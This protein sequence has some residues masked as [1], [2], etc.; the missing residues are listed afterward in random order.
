[1]DKENAPAALGNTERGEAETAKSLYTE[2]P[3]ISTW[4]AGEVVEQYHF[5]NLYPLD[6]QGAAAA[7]QHLHGYGPSYDTVRTFPAYA[8]DSRATVWREWQY[9][10]GWKARD[11]ILPEMTVIVVALCALEAFRANRDEGFNVNEAKAETDYRKLRQRHLGITVDKAIKLA[12]AQTAVAAWNP[13]ANTIG[14]PAGECLYLTPTNPSTGVHHID[15]EPED[16]LTRALAATPGKTTRLWQDFLETL[17]G[18]DVL[19]ENALKVW[20]AAALFDGNPHHKAH[21]LYGDGNTGKSTY[22][23][24]IQAALGDYAGSARASVFTSEKDS[25]PAELLPFV[26]K[27]L[28]VL[29][30]LPL[31]AL[32]SDLLK[33]VTGGDSISVRGMRQNPRTETP[34]ATLMFSANELPSIRLVDN[35]L[36]RRLLVWPF[37]TVPDT[38]DLAL[39]DKLASEEH[40]GGVVT[41]L[42]GG[43]RA[44]LR[45]LHT[46]ADMPIPDAVANATAD[47]F[48][49]ADTVGQWADASLIDG[50]ETLAASLY[51]SFKAWTEG[52]GRKALSERSFGLWMGR[53]YDRQRSKAGN[54]YPVTINGYYPES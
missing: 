51:L 8:Y 15:Q 52:R 3:D 53:H 16:Y 27:R 30:E 28:V 23:K 33:T 40:L 38:I 12:A 5:L 11:T 54:V 31:G 17:T 14:L 7:F 45:I 47:Y 41:W 49:D 42:V 18:G 10:N 4:T 9:P 39:G 13:D 26:D 22:L 34:S 1:M 24:T 44:Y 36:K 25:H 29:P 19:I 21:I 20:T 43:I 48:R 6:I 50:G 2:T 35:A 37:N 46:G 32:R